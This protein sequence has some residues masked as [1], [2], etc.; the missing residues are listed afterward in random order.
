MKVM[1]QALAAQEECNKLRAQLQALKDKQAADEFKLPDFEPAQ[2]NFSLS[3][4]ANHNVK[5]APNQA[6]CIPPAV[7]STTFL[8][9]AVGVSSGFSTPSSTT[10]SASAT[11]SLPSTPG[12]IG[13]SPASGSSLTV[14]SKNPTTLLEAGV[15]HKEYQVFLYKSL[16]MWTTSRSLLKPKL[17]NKLK[18]KMDDYTLLKL[19]KNNGLFRCRDGSTYYTINKLMLQ[20]PEEKDGLLLPRDQVDWIYPPNDCVGRV[21]DDVY[22]QQQEDEVKRIEKELEDEEDDDLLSAAL[23]EDDDLKNDANSNHSLGNK[24]TLNEAHCSEV[25]GQEPPAKKIK[26]DDGGHPKEEK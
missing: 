20:N 21:Y 7:S 23:A 8:P 17:P 19:G 5:P 26:L 22:R 13:E 25:C 11:L 15:K 18:M 16:T 2:F 24:A 4:S 3:S 12:S 14:K 1:K 6:I 9:S 10:P